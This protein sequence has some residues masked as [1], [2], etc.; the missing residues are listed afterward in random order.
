MHKPQQKE[1]CELANIC[2]NINH[3][4]YI[5]DPSWF[6]IKFEIGVWAFI[7]HFPKGY[8]SRSWRSSVWSEVKVRSHFYITFRFNELWWS[9]HSPPYSPVNNIKT[10][11]LQLALPFLGRYMIECLDSKFG[12]FCLLHVFCLV[13]NMLGCWMFSSVSQFHTLVQCALKPMAT[14]DWTLH[15]LKQTFPSSHRMAARVSVCFNL[16]LRC[17]TSSILFSTPLYFQA[18]NNPTALVRNI[19]CAIYTNLNI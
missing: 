12:F 9:C 1:A 13:K 19:G 11:K 14:A 15:R 4:Y 6:L 2:I 8:Q 3:V 5:T 7:F 10:L 17:T 18:T 16:L